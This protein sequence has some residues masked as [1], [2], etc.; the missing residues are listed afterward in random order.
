[1]Q[2]LFIEDNLDIIEKSESC[3]VYI[4]K[5]KDEKFSEVL[6]FKDKTGFTLLNYVCDTMMPEFVIG[7]NRMYDC[8]VFDINE[9]KKE[10]SIQHRGI[11]EFVSL[12]DKAEIR[13]IKICAILDD[14][15]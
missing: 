4:F 7:V 12:K 13:K 9:N 10:L 8:I 5:L 11:K 6:S 15:V 14:D 1:M 3:G 2:Y